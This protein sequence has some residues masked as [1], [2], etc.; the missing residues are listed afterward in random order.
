[1]MLKENGK[2]GFTLIELMIVVAIIG[3]LAAIAIPQ[4]KGHTIH[5]KITEV[6]NAMAYIASALNHHSQELGIKG[7]KVTWPNCPDIAAIQTSLGVGLG[8]IA[9]IGSAKI[10]PPTGVIQ[11]TLNH[12]DASV[13]GQTLLLMPT[14]GD[15][16]IQWV[17]GGTVPSRYL[18]KE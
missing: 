8:G 7:E 14:L 3:I 10:A 6:T 2:R 13:D 4:Y 5:A 15:S 12:I 16:G 17:W 1:M 18:P 9:R 11:V